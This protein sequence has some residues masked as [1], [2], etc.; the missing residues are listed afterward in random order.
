MSVSDQI[1]ETERRIFLNCYIEE[2]AFENIESP[3]IEGKMTALRDLIEELWLTDL[4]N[5]WKEEQGTE[6]KC[7]KKMR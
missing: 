2:C 3:L 7:G 1:S 4:Y 5:Q 6:K